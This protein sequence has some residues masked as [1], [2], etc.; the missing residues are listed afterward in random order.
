MD[1]RRRQRSATAV[2]QPAV[3]PLRERHVFAAAVR[4]A[5]FAADLWP[6]A[7]PRRQGAADGPGAATEARGCGAAPG[8]CAGAAIFIIIIIIIFI[9]I[10]IITLHVSEC[11]SRAKHCVYTWLLNPKAESLKYITLGSI[12]VVV[13][14][15]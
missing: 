15:C 9:V 2:F 10:I 6:A 7:G 4:P 8:A 14:F 13:C 1:R 5:V 12:F 11:V 3:R